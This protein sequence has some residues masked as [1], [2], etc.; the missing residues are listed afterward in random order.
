MHIF[1]K[2]MKITIFLKYHS[3]TYTSNRPHC[4]KIICKVLFKYWSST[5]RISNIQNQFPISHNPFSN[6]MC[7]NYNKQQHTNHMKIKT[8]FP[9]RNHQVWVH[10]LQD[11]TM[12]KI[13]EGLTISVGSRKQSHAKTINRHGNT[14]NIEL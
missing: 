12:H 1:V 11:K 2:D 6:K 4:K 10:D 3:K 8:Y 14:H 9:C 7:N 13:T 5:N